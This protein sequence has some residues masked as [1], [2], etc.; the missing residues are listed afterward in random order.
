MNTLF[1][2]K[3]KFAERF[4]KLHSLR[5]HMTLILMATICSGFLMTR[6]LLAMHVNNVLVRYPLA[7]IV[8]YLVFFIAIKLWLKYIS[9]TRTA[10]ITKARTS[11]V[12]DAVDIPISGPMG[13]GSPVSEVFQGGGGG[14]S[15][16]G[17]SANF[18][19]A[20]IAF[21]RSGTDVLAG[22]MDS[23]GGIGEAVGDAAG[24]AAS[25]LGDEG[26]VVVLVIF[27]VL[28]AA[29]A[30]VVGTGIYLVYEAPFILSEA[31]FNFCLAASLVRGTRRIH[32]D[33]WMGSVLKTTGIPFTVTLALSLLA[34]YLI[35]H[36]FPGVTRISELFLRL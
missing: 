20:G 2:Q 30:T 14:F 9:P 28:A 26:G 3:I 25:A 21:T 4:K 13:G 33:D 12:L 35:H 10:N 8:A 15:G 1:Q 34:G 24:D 23:S 17:A 36:Y 5:F 19:E 18:D 27:A 22:S 31:A 32:S 7:V 29:L 6:L 11:S 16:A